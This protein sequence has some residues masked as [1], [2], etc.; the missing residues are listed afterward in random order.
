MLIEKDKTSELRKPFKLVVAGSRAFSDYSLLEEKLDLMLS[1]KLAE[2]FDI[3]IISGTAAGADIL[4]EKYAE[5]KGFYLIRMPAD[6]DKHGNVSGFIRNAEMMAFADAAV[7]FW[8]GKSKGT[9]HSIICAEKKGIPFQVIRFTNNFT[10]DIPDS[11]D[12]V[13]FFDGACIS[14]GRNGVGGIGFVVYKDKKPIMEFSDYIGPATNNEA[15]YKALISC[16][17]YLV[18]NY[19]T[20]RNILIKGDSKL[21]INQVTEVFGCS[22]E[23]LR[24]LLYKANQL[25]SRFDSLQFEWIP[26]ELN[27]VAD[28]LSQKALGGIQYDYYRR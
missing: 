12:L 27:A 24:P 6:W 15:E 7:F 5:E 26:R 3:V 28:E 11:Y 9:A 16:L 14:N 1:K 21:V 23:N 18:D 8:D 20:N 10:P 22:S 19:Y 13:C 17:S 4:G 25:K 2:S